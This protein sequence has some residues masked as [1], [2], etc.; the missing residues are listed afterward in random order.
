MLNNYNKTSS[1]YSSMTI[2]A[3][4]YSTPGIQFIPNPSLNNINK[5]K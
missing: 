5:Y 2:Q 1:D 3:R 4:P